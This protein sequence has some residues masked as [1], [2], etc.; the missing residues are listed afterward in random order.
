MVAIFRFCWGIYMSTLFNE[1]KNDTAWEETAAITAVKKMAK[2][3][4]KIMQQKKI[5]MVYRPR[6]FEEG[7]FYWIEHGHDW[8]EWCVSWS[9]SSSNLG[10][11]LWKNDRTNVIELASKS[12]FTERY[13]RSRINYNWNF[14]IFWSYNRTTMLCKSLMSFIIASISPNYSPFTW[15]LPKKSYF[16]RC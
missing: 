9:K 12:I 8:T 10:H 13:A 6:R 7:C 16:K 2:E 15:N 11:Y 3:I 5:H 14:S 1:Q 4:K